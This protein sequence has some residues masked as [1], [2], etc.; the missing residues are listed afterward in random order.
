MGC[1]AVAD[2]VN[3]RGKNQQNGTDSDA[4]EPA[5]AS[6][7][8]EIDGPARP[9]D[10]FGDPGA[11]IPLTEIDR[12]QFRAAPVVGVAPFGFVDVVLGHGVI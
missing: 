12:D 6:R 8:G 11:C 7:L 5:K 3:G 9:G 1:L 10:L 4:V 2:G